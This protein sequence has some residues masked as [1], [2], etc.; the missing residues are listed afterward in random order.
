M[1]PM[2]TQQRCISVNLHTL[3]SAGLLVAYE[4]CARKAFWRNWAKPKLPPVEIL[5]TTLQHVLTADGHPDDE[6][7]GDFAGST[8]LDLA[9]SPGIAV[10]DPFKSAMNLSCLADLLVTV[11]R[12]ENDPPWLIPD[13]VGRWKPSCLLAP[14]GKSLRRIVLVSHWVDERHYAE[15]RSWFCL[16][17]LAHYGLP[18]QM[19]VLIIGLNRSGRYGSHWTRALQHPKGFSPTSVD[20]L[21][22]RRRGGNV[23]GGFKDTWIEIFREDHD[24]IPRETWIKAMLADDVMRDVILRVDVPAMSAA[25]CRRWQAL[26]R[27]KLDAISRLKYKPALELAPCHWPVP[28]QFVELCHNTPEREPARHLGFVEIVPGPDPNTQEEPNQKSNGQANDQIVAHA[29]KLNV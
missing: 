27:Q 14:D 2:W 28:C 10:P 17:E 7:W 9:A 4:T 18:M 16:G 1:L 23:N 25:D 22:F 8:V 6:T 11:L 15:C 24:E 12:K 3:S 13:P 21:R 20:K 29:C 26:A 19:V 5:R